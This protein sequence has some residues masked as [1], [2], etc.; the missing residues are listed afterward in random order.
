MDVDAYVDESETIQCRARTDDTELSVA[1]NL[2]VTD[3]RLIHIE[4]SDSLLDTWTI[5]L[6]DID[7]VTHEVEPVSWGGVALGG[8][9]AAAGVALGWHSPLAD[10]LPSIVFP[11]VAAVLVLFGAALVFDAFN[12]RT[13]R[14]QVE[15]EE[16]RVFEGRGLS[17]CSEAIADSR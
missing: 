11:V 16:R 1:G 6:D 9:L 17:E 8:I 13:E 7:D 14:L 4:A 3:R 10:T 2:A 12:T 5:A 15:G